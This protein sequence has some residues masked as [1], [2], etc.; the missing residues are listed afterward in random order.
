M[1][2]STLFLNGS[3]LIF[4]KWFSPMWLL[5]SIPRQNLMQAFWAVPN[6]F[7]SDI[8]SFRYQAQHAKSK[9]G[10][11]RE[12]HNILFRW[13]AI[14]PIKN[15]VLPLI[16]LMPF[17]PWVLQTWFHLEDILSIQ[18]QNTVQLL[19]NFR[20]YRQKWNRSVIF[21]FCIFSFFKYGSYFRC[22][23]TFRKL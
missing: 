15:F 14:L 12:L 21:W 17:L 1:H 8:D 6:L 20:H 4:S 19:N 7:F 22:F 2:Q 9:C 5:L 10:G 13:Y 3:Q 18:L 16:F 23:T 11:I